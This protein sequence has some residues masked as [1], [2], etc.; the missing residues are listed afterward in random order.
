MTT[1][2]AH[3]N[4]ADLIDEHVTFEAILRF[5]KFEGTHPLQTLFLF[6]FE[7]GGET[8]LP[9]QVVPAERIVLARVF[10]S[11]FGSLLQFA[12]KGHLIRHVCLFDRTSPLNFIFLSFSKVE[13][14]GDLGRRSLIDC[15]I[16]EQ[17]QALLV[18]C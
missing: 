16:F 14:V 12:L 13:K 18:N 8:P 1:L 3:V 4:Q 5:D 2:L 17:F 6:Y 11:N 7:N 10:S 15:F 9:Q